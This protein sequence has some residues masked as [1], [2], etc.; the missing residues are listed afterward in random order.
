MFMYPGTGSAALSFP[1]VESLKDH[2]RE[3][4]GIPHTSIGFTP[5]LGVDSSMY[6]YDLLQQSTFV[7]IAA[8]L[9]AP[10]PSST[11]FPLASPRFRGDL[12]RVYLSNFRVM[13]MGWRLAGHARV[14][15][16]V[17]RNNHLRCGRIRC[18]G[19]SAYPPPTRRSPGTRPGGESLH[20]RTV[21][22]R[23]YHQSQNNFP[24]LGLLGRDHGG[25]K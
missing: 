3:I 16:P 24:L 23:I 22:A 14:L 12:L 20:D 4:L 13:E 2:W 19:G 15:R 17:R 18:L 10:A 9:I 6:L 21:G 8:L 25:W 7:I 5:Y 11:T 1:T